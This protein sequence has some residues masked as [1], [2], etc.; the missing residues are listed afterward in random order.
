VAQERKGLREVVVVVFGGGGKGAVPEV[1]RQPVATAVAVQ[2]VL[3]RDE[4]LD[5]GAV[6]RKLLQGE[7]GD[8]SRGVAAE[9]RLDAGHLG[10]RCRG[11]GWR[12]GGGGWHGRPST[13]GLPC[14]CG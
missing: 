5:F 9:R 3:V 2:R 13:D 11:W 10:R 6:P 7:T 14:R 4:G 1:R 8:P 12:R